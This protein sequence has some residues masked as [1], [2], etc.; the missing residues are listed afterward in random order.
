[1]IAARRRPTVAVVGH[2]EWISHV[3]G[4]MPAAGR[5]SYLTAPIEE[6]GGGG[7]IAAAQIA[8][9]GARCLFLT[10]LGDDHWGHRARIELEGIG[11]EVRAALRAEG[12][13]RALS[14]VGPSG[15]RAI[16]VVG[17]TIHP[18][19]ADDLGWDDLAD[20]DAVY[21]TGRDAA[22]LALARRAPR[23]VVHSRRREVLREAAQPVDVVVGSDDDPDESVDPD[24]LPA[25]VGAAVWT[26]GADGGIVR[27]DGGEDT[28]EAVPPPGV[29]V[30]SYGCGDS[31]A[32][33]LTVG[34]AR[35]DA[36]MDAVRLGARCGAANITGRGG[37]Q[38]Q[39]RED[40]A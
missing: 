6:P 17:T 2:V 12:Q 15:D 24:A 29:P 27:A 8:K 11:I 7:A 35:G 26:R 9:L 38:A 34:L 10:A 36:L 3:L 4:R 22:T 37:L 25:P 23:L 32:G 40:A 39:L 21:F 14:A 5:I 18:L 19:A 31:F 13:T 1:M 28:W 33:G 20:V 16:A 30:D